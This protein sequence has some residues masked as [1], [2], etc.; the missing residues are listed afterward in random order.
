[1]SIESTTGYLL[2]L[3]KDKP[4]HL[5]VHEQTV[6][7]V[8]SIDYRWCVLDLSYRSIIAAS[9]LDACPWLVLFAGNAS[10]FMDPLETR[11]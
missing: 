6:T 3:G 11:F 9:Q 7:V 1:M 8:V 4:R 5:G 10:S 2:F